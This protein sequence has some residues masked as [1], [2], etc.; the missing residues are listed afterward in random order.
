MMLRIFLF[1]YLTLFSTVVLTKEIPVIVIS[2]GKTVQSYSSVGSQIT[3]INS[4]TIENSLDSFLT[5]LLGDEAQGLNIFQLGGKGTNAGIQLRG[6]PKRYSTVYID[7][8]KMNDPSASE[9]GF[10]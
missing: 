2:A 6:L 8:V 3:I 4:E 10:Y 1:L 9:N 5:D 7:G